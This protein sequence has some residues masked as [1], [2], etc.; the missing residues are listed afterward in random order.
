MR[1]DITRHLSVLLAVLF[2]A[3][4]PTLAT[5]PASVHEDVVW[6]EFRERIDLRADGTAC[7]EVGIVPG[8]GVSREILVPVT[9]G[10]LVSARLTHPV[11]QDIAPE[12]L[13]GTSIV[14]VSL[15]SFSETINEIK[16]EYIASGAFAPAQALKSDYG[17]VDVK[18][19]FVQLHP[20]MISSF[21]AEIVLPS[22]LQLKAVDEFSP[23]AK[24]DDPNEPY[25]LRQTPDGRKTVRIELGKVVFGQ[26]VSM[27]WRQYRKDGQ[28]GLFT[29]LL[30]AAALYLYF[31]RDLV[32]VPDL[33]P[34]V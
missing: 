1:Q 12:T 29:G 3:V 4:S 7:V 16:V 27:K 20:A 8:K 2:F 22:G 5:E 23:K 30:L 24:K 26:R 9:V 17:N 34:A 28:Y 33:T 6:N 21:S 13:G 32:K 25:V 18:Y 10:R 15:G 31:F 19:Q 11:S 14:R